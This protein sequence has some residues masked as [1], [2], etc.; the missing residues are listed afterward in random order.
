MSEV[1]LYL[2]GGPEPADGRVS[3]NYLTEMCS[4][5]EEG[6][7]L[8]LID[9]WDRQARLGAIPRGWSRASR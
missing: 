5:S 2:E 4:G 7:Y 6:A 9:F 3:R 1:P 8:R